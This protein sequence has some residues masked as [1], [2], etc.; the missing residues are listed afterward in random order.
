[1]LIEN[2]TLL[3]L[4]FVTYFIFAYTEGNTCIIISIYKDVVYVLIYP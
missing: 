3:N 2:H 4:A 1:M